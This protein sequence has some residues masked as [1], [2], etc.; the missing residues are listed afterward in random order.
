MTQL[1]S[2]TVGKF[3]GLIG[4]V[5]EINDL[6]TLDLNAYGKISLPPDQIKYVQPIKHDFVIG[7]TVFSKF[8]GVCTITDIMHNGMICLTTPRGHPASCYYLDLEKYPLEQPITLRDEI[9]QL[10]KERIAILA[11]GPVAPEGV[12]IEYGKVPKR[13]FIQAYYRANKPIFPPKGRTNST[14]GLS[15]RKYIGKKDSEKDLEAQRAIARRNRL[16]AIDRKIKL[17]REKEQC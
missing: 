16:Q 11:E 2:P 5:V 3:K 6:V 8:L 10:E 15:S 14:S 12:W 7:D 13:K 1:A 9:T 4:A 17:L